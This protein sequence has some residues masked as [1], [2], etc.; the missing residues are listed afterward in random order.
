MQPLNFTRLFIVL[1][2]FLCSCRT[3]RDIYSPSVPGNPFFKQKGDSKV[4]G[5]FSSGNRNGNASFNYGYDVQAAYAPVNHLAVT[6]GTYQRREKDTYA[7]T[8]YNI[9][10]SSAVRYKRNFTEIGVG[11]FSP[12]AKGSNITFNLYTGIGLGGF[13]IDDRGLTDSSAYSRDYKTRMTKWYLQPG[14]NFIISDYFRLGL[15]LRLAWVNYHH[16]NTSYSS[17]ELDYFFLNKISN[18]VFL[19]GESTL[20]MQVGFPRLQ[21]MKLDMGASF[22]PDQAGGYPH[23]RNFNGFAG[24]TF[25]LPSRIKKSGK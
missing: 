12:F 13:S 11:Y 14:I 7:G 18:R 17:S 24:L 10:D 4:S 21:W 16:I 5:F 3:P 23:V 8:H 2:F 19:Y 25:S 20:N 15:V 1:T 6:I 22:C 9:F